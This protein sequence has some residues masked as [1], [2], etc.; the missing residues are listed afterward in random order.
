VLGTAMLVI[1]APWLIWNQHIYGEFLV[2][3]AW[4]KVM[5]G[6]ISRHSLASHY[7]LI[8]FPRQFTRSFIGTFGWWNLVLPIWVYVL[9]LV[10]LLSAGAC[11]LGGVWRRRI[12]F[13]LTA[14]LSAL[15]VL[16]VMAVVHVNLTFSAPL[17]RYMLP[18]L[19]AVALL[20]GLGLES[21]RSWSEFRTTLT[22]G[23]LAVSN[24]IILLAWVIPAYW[25]PVIRT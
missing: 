2:Q 23:A 13:R 15:I 21:L 5:G 20:I 17:G 25:P 18:A 14:I 11:W 6:Q 3:K 16:N 19:P 24:L 22:L 12:D 9:Y 7:F 4:V 8:D 10:A 1:V